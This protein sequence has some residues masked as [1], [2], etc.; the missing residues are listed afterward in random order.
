[1]MHNMPHQPKPANQSNALAAVKNP[2]LETNAVQA[3]HTLM[4]L[5][6]KI[7]DVASRESQSIAMD[8]MIGFHA[9]QDE[10]EK[11]SFEYQQACGEFHK[12]LSDFRRVDPA[13]ISQLE[14]LQEE[15][16]SLSRA[17]NEAIKRIGEAAGKRT[18]ATL[19]E[20][21]ELAQNVHIRYPGDEK[22]EKS[23]AAETHT[24]NN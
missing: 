15:I 24:M 6:R 19:L 22:R 16:G 5:S 14:K 21:Q 13:L 3:V 8:D 1:M 7:I 10:K 20:A 2:Y 11:L 17:N 23:P 4:R 9:L 12:R 18:E